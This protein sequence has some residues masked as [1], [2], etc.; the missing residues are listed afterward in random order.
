MQTVKVASDVHSR[1]VHLASE[2]G[3]T[4]GSVISRSLDV[5]EES[6]FWAAVEHTMVA[7]RAPTQAD[8]FAGTL[9]DG[10][11]PAETWEDIL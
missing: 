3:T 5:L 1:L 2:R 11:D 8:E 4:I 6:E 10:L 9:M 7:T